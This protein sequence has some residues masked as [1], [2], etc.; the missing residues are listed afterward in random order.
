MANDL[1]NTLKRI[2][3]TVYEGITQAAVQKNEITDKDD[4]LIQK[5]NENVV[6]RNNAIHAVFY[7][8]YDPMR[9]NGGSTPLGLLVL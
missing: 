2:E 4:Y 1:S 7:E 5:E 3:S 8:V 6:Y 9:D